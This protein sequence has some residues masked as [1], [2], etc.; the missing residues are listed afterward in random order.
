MTPRFEIRRSGLGRRRWR[1]VLIGGNGEVLMVSEHLNSRHAANV[2]ICAV[3]AAAH[4]A[5]IRDTTR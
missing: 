5:G 1:V 3:V 2:N 4:H